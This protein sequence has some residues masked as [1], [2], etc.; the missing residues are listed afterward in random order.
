MIC[1][2]CSAVVALPLDDQAR[3]L[4]EQVHVHIGR[5][6]SLG[7]WPSE[8][9]RHAYM[10]L[11]SVLGL[12]LAY[13]EALSAPDATTDRCNDA[14]GVLALWTPLLRTRPPMQGMRPAAPEAPRPAARYGCSAWLRPCLAEA[15]PGPS[16]SATATAARGVVA[17]PTPSTTS[18]PRHSAGRTIRRAWPA[19]AGTATRPEAA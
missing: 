12:Y 15:P 4:H 19:H 18:C 1:P 5:Q 8:V 7:G 10:S 2:S 17:R 16:S 11:S 6:Q 3:E 9:E 14:Q 13:I